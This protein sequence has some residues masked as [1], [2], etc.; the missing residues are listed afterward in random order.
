[1]GKILKRYLKRY[2]SLGERNINTPPIKKGARLVGLG[3]ETGSLLGK[4][5]GLGGTEN[6]INVHLL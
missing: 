6:L 1:V 4:S 2:T 5:W 3:G